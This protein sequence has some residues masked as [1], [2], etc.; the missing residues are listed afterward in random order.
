M[1]RVSANKANPASVILSSPFE[2][3]SVILPFHISASPTDPVTDYC[4]DATRDRF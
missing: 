3:L 4:L 2:D 1:N